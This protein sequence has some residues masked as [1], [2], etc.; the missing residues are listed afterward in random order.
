[1][2][3][4][5]LAGSLLLATLPVFA[6]EPSGKEQVTV[7]LV[8]GAFA[9]GSS[10]NKVVPLLQAKGLKVVA[11]QNPLT[12]LAD[13]VAA[14][15]RAIDP[16]AGPVVLVGHSWG[17]TVITEA[18]N[19]E[20]VKALV[21][22][23]AFAPSP[24]ESSNDGGKGYPPPPGLAHPVASR[25]GFLALTPEAIAQDFAQDVGPEEANL[26]AVSQGPV[27]STAFDTKVTAAAWTSKPS[28]YIVSTKDRMIQPDAE[29]AFAKKIKAKTT[30]L[31]P[32]HVPM[33]SQP[34]AVADVIAAAAKAI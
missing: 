14:T 15:K 16:Q 13:D 31:P 30:E 22:V 24:G 1:M 33:L 2:K 17:G 32:S 4:A 28:W 20:K 11:V 18:G 9:D 26:I 6:S 3:I 27:N 19:D 10:W 34:T 23:A 8:H 21:Y 5:I 7:V 25:D 29:R 12:T